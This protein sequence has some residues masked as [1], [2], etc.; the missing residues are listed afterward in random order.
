MANLTVPIKV[1]ALEIAVQHAVEYYKQGAFDFAQ[2]LVDNYDNMPPITSKDDF[3]N[4]IA[5]ILNKGDE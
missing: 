1:D 5:E 4:W 3:A 2:K